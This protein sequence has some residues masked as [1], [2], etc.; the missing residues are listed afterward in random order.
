VKLTDQTVH[1]LPLPASGN[2]VFYDAEAKGFGCRVT[3]KGARSF[4]LNYRTRDGRERRY[5]IGAYPDWKATAARA[6]ARRLKLAI[7]RGEDPMGEIHAARGAVKARKEAE[8]FAEAVEDYITREQKGRRQNATASEIRRVLLKECAAWRHLPVIEIQARDIRKM[9][10]TIRDGDGKVKPR[11]Y[12]ANRT[13]A[14]L[15]TFFAWCAETGID[16][17]PASPMIGLK[18]PFEGEEERSRVWSDDE[19][20]AL[21]RASDEIGGTAGAFLKI[22]L[23]TGKRKS[24]LAA[25]RWAEI[26]DKGLWTPAADNRRRRGNKRRHVIPLPGMA[27]AAIEALRP[28]QADPG[29]YVFAGRRGGSHLDPGTSLQK[30]IQGESD[31]A[32]FFFHGCKHTAETRMAELGVLPHIRDMLFDHA[33]ARGA[34]AGYDH[35]HYGPEMR[36][37]LERWAGHIEKLVTPAEV[38]PL[39]AATERVGAIVSPSQNIAELL[40]TRFS[41]S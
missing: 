10:E 38:L 8:T 39:R 30:M 22:A 31:V 9:C 36:D 5:T 32:D 40:S 28:A 7:D 4:V 18:R 34:G 11:P 41:R 25:M 16:K 13:F 33:P 23:L 17:A 37:A 15:K 20:R 35:H 2:K 24:Q 3:A 19:L 12:L 26:D 1:D 14:Y 27:L 29:A 21:W 6:E